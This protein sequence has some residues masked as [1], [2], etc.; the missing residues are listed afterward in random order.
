MLRNLL[1]ESLKVPTTM[2]A[3]PGGYGGEDKCSC[4]SLQYQHKV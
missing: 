2:M 4:G 1:V 3:D